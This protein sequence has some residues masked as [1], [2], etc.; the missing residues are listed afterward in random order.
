MPGDSTGSISR[1]TNSSQL[2][3]KAT[4]T[5]RISNKQEEDSQRRA[6]PAPRAWASGVNPI[7]QRANTPAQTNG[8]L[9]RSSAKSAGI[10][11]SGS[12]MDKI[13]DRQIQVLTHSMGFP[14]TI[15]TKDGNAY[16][17]QPT[18]TKGKHSELQ[19]V[20][21]NTRKA[22]DADFEKPQRNLAKPQFVGEGAQHILTI[23]FSQIAMVVSSDAA[24]TVRSAQGQGFKTDVEIS[25]NA[26][27]LS[28][29]W[30]AGRL[31]QTPQ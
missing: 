28:G 31:L 9:S 23:S 30:S 11:G 5:S 10:D 8:S 2:L 3:G 7:T 6:Q 26:P 15:T 25:G 18:A 12:S 21:Q 22:T 24:G 1:V 13:Q 14:C 19:F 4:M 20:F 29:S 16:V 17:G 27:L